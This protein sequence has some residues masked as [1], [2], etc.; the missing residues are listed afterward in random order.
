LGNKTALVPTERIDR[1]IL[2]FRG[3]RIMLD[4]DL[5]NLYG[6]EVKALNQAVK[7]NLERFPAD[8]MFQLT[9]K[10]TEILRS[11]SVTSSS[12][13]GR[14]TFPYAFT[15]QGVAMLSQYVRVSQRLD[16]R[17][18]AAASRN[19]AETRGDSSRVW[20]DAAERPESAWF[21]TQSFYNYRFS[22]QNGL[23]RHPRADGP[24]REEAAQDRV[25]GGG[26]QEVSSCFPVCRLRS[27]FF[28]F[29][30]NVIM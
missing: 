28:D 22:V 13:G 19:I 5:A 4:E 24:S 6:V 9:K 10:E 30:S 8:F 7:R 23:R 17:R 21:G 2:A 1:T 18:A 15:E 27:P 3:H 16:V 26:T 12:W 25:Q 20:I 11:Q 14:R 29:K